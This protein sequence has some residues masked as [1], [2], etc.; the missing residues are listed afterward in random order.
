MF[1][2]MTQNT[3]NNTIKQPYTTL[4]RRVSGIGIIRTDAYKHDYRHSCFTKKKKE[5]G[6]MT[7]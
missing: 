4:N 5:T 1:S 2:I 3:H 7:K 6:K